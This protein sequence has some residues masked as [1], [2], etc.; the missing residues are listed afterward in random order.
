ML[1]SNSAII[2]LLVF[3][4]REPSGWNHGGPGG[5]ARRNIINI[6][7]AGGKRENHRANE[8]PGDCTIGMNTKK[9]NITI[10]MTGNIKLCASRISE[11]A[12]PMARKIEP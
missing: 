3:A 2:S 6:G 5:M 9:G 7:V 12:E 8:L 4:P 10:I 1:A 11:H